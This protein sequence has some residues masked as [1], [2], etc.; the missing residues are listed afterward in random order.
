M[1]PQSPPRSPTTTGAPA[2]RGGGTPCSPGTLH[3]PCPKATRGVPKP[4]GGPKGT[5]GSR[6]HWRVPKPQQGF[7]SHRGVPKSPEG[8]KATRGRGPEGTEGSQSN[9][10]VP[11]APE[12][13]EEMGGSQSQ[14]GGPEVTGVSRRHGGE[15]P[16]PSG[17]RSCEAPLPPRAPLPVPKAKEPQSQAGSRT[18]GPAAMA[19]S[20]EAAA[21]LQEEA[22]CAICLDLFRSPVMLD[23]GHNFCQ[24]CIGLCWARSAGAPSCPQCRQALPSR[25]LRP[26]RQLG[27]IAAGLRRLGQTVEPRQVRGSQGGLWSTPGTRFGA[28]ALSEPVWPG[29][30]P[31]CVGLA[32]GGCGASSGDSQHP[33]GHPPV[34]WG[35]ARRRVWARRSPE[36]TS[37]L[38]HSG[39]RSAHS[40]LT[41]RLQIMILHLHAS[42]LCNLSAKGHAPCKSTP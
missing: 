1:V 41:H 28:R 29:L 11:K 21:E 2:A 18:L 26:N 8:P 39:V 37:N 15:V 14:E 33:P 5:E 6:S 31:C 13:L 36:I 30:G 20:S 32:Q 23:C 25:S 22:T 35:S 12:G 42:E 3:L 7:Q 24:A 34:L 9:R 10:R 40:F 17:S 16:Q 38:G 27:N 19:G 4:R